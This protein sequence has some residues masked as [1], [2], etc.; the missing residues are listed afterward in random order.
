MSTSDAQKVLKGLE[1]IRSDVEGY[2]RRLHTHPELGMMEVETAGLVAKLLREWGFE[3][4]ERIGRT[5]VVG[6]LR[7][8]PGPCVLARADMDALP[9]REETGLSYAS[10]VTGR[11]RFGNEFPVMHACGHDLHTAGLL[12]AARLMASARDMWQGTLEV[13]FQP[14][15]ETG[16]GAAGM[17][18]DGL[19][20][21][22]PAPDVAL[23]QHVLP[24]RAGEVKICPGP[25]LSSAQLFDITIHGRGAH[26]SMP[27]A[28]IDPVVIA[29]STVLALQT[30][31]SRELAAKTPASLTVGKIRAGN[32]GNVIADTAELQLSTRS[33]DDGTRAHFEASIRRIVDAVA[34]AAGVQ[35]KPDVVKIVDTEPVINDPEVSG[36]VAA[37]FA[38]FFGAA[39]AQTGSTT[40]SEDFPEIPKA[41]GVPYLYWVI[42]C[43]DSALFDSGKAIPTNHSPQFAPA[44]QPTLDTGV[45][46]MVVAFLV[47]LGKS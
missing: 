13:L 19:T 22:I 38:E 31:V 43:T 20:D 29:A 14:G 37:A 24:F 4:V 8:G 12:G 47:W 6:I 36:K 28:A 40:P 5:G 41:F 2:Y 9:V 3:V 15:E 44:L 7:N 42:G 34:Q 46:A 16:A 23:A 45:Q 1:G 33:Y 11:D 26:G 27:E 35:K 17:V 39:Y 25:F 32:A 30:I 10:T 21:R 18:A